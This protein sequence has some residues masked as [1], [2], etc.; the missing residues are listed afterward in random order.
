M[1]SCVLQAARPEPAPMA[2]TRMDLDRTN[3]ARDH[4]N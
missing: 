1:I 2:I 4:K 3:A